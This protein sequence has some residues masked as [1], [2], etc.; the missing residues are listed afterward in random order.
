MSSNAVRV[1]EAGIQ[2]RDRRM[3]KAAGDR[4]A[5]LLWN[6]SP[7]LA[8][9]RC[10]RNGSALQAQRRPKQPTWPH[11][12]PWFPAR[13]A[14]DLGVISTICVLGPIQRQ[15]CLRRHCTSSTSVTRNYYERAELA[16]TT[17]TKIHHSDFGRQPQ[18]FLSAVHT[19]KTP[20]RVGTTTTTRT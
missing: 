12:G 7:V 3:S 13:D 15:L 20:S 1:F 11:T 5:C 8:H 19:T 4:V 6:H 17:A 16:N 18:A 2:L 14:T 9:S 10:R